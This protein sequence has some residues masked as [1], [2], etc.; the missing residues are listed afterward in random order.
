MPATRQDF[1]HFNLS[2]LVSIFQVTLFQRDFV[3]KIMHFQ[4]VTQATY[5]TLQRILS[6]WK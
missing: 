5:V 6:V 2:P 3:V 4:F 1:G